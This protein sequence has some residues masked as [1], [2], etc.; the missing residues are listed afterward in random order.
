MIRTHEARAGAL[1]VLMFALTGPAAAAT[2][3]LYAAGS[4]QAMLSDVAKTYQSATGITV[5][6]KYG[7]SGLLKNEISEGAKADVFASANME[8]PQALHDGKEKRPSGSF[9]AQ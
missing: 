1:A 3:N 7:P 8:H 5:S 2:I 6:A 4:L 9:C